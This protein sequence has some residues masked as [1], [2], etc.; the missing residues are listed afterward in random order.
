MN[1]IRQQRDFLEARDEQRSKLLQKEILI[2]ENLTQ[3]LEH[4][5]AKYK[6]AEE[7]IKFVAR[8]RDSLFDAAHDLQHKIDEDRAAAEQRVIA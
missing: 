7:K 4:M 2:Q 8:Q 5:E 1:A 6:D 3:H